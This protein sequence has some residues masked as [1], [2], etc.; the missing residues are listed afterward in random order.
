M[1]ILVNTDYNIRSRELP[2]ESIDNEDHSWGQ[3]PSCGAYGLPKLY[4]LNPQHG[5]GI[6]KDAD[7]LCWPRL[8][9]SIQGQKQAAAAGREPCGCR[10]AADTGWQWQTQRPE[11]AGPIVRRL[12]YQ[13]SYL[14]YDRPVRA[15]FLSLEEDT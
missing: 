8:E 5:T 15:T 2:T 6:V 1:D 9:A 14:T 11:V 13:V 3:E 10:V 7:D 4:T 12:W